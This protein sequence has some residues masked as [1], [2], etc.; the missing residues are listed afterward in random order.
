MTFRNKRRWPHA[1]LEERPKLKETLWMVLV[2][3]DYLGNVIVLRGWV[4]ETISARC[5]R[6]RHKNRRWAFM[7]RLVDA[8]FFWDANHCESAYQNE[9]NR[10]YSPPELRKG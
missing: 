5:W 9:L 2:G 1:S 4:S 10:V 6:L 3:V 7:R 8:L